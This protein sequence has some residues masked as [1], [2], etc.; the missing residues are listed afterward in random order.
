[1]ATA[2]NVT[3][4]IDIVVSQLLSKGYSVQCKDLD[5]FY[6]GSTCYY[7]EKSYGSGRSDCSGG[8]ICV[9]TDGTYAF[10]LFNG[11]NNRGQHI[12]SYSNNE[13]VLSVDTL[14]VEKIVSFMF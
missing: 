4:K 5:W 7:F 13:S 12:N 11:G 6:G 3:T 1:M 8:H 9:L 14:P 2:T 10:D